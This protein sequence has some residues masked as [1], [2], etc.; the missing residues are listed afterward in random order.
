MRLAQSLLHA[1]LGI[2][3][4]L[5]YVGDGLPTGTGYALAEQ[6]RGYGSFALLA[7]LT[8]LFGGL[9][10]SRLRTSGIL[11][12]VPRIRS[13]MVMAADHA[14]APT[15]ACALGAAAAVS[16]SQAVSGLQP[17]VDLRVAIASVLQCLVFALF[18]LAVG[19]C[20]P[21]VVSLPAA[22]ILPYLLIAFPPAMQ[23]YWLRHI[24]G[25]SS[26]CCWIYEDLSHRALAAHIA[27]LI[28]TGLVAGAIIL[29]ALG[30]TRLV[31]PSLVMVAAATLV[32]AARLVTGFGPIAVE[33][34]SGEP[35]CE[36]VGTRK[37]CLWP[38][39][40]EARASAS[41]LLAQ[42][43]GS[44][45]QLVVPEE[46]T[47]ESPGTTR[48]PAT[49]WEPW[50]GEPMAQLSSLVYAMYPT[51]AP[52]QGQPWAAVGADLTHE[53]SLVRAWWAKRV[54]LDATSFL[55]S[56]NPEAAKQL[57]NVLLMD[58]AAQTARINE[59]VRARAEGCAS[60]E[61]K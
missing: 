37:L 42:I 34:R 16:Y 25:I 23:P 36:S 26:N 39:H 8:S 60:G 61:F 12:S 11:R 52:S 17:S 3:A 55:P 15:L 14:L 21:R 32:V 56:E 30:A 50:P 7:P 31:M 51:C 47:E 6:I 59:L 43:L 4:G 9:A 53:G 2:I 20:A 24:S 58:E 28:A 38:D 54:G 40:E 41:R 22:V 57:Q 44:S 19:L 29:P 10:G 18:G 49:H 48:W 13:T 46:F 5:L 35:L 27:F 1:L 45:S 33:P